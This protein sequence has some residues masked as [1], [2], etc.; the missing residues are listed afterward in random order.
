MSFPYDSDWPSS[1]DPA[2][3]LHSERT[4]VASIPQSYSD[5][6]EALI[7]TR[8]ELRAEHNEKRTVIQHRAWN[9][10]EIFR[11]EDSFLRGKILLATIQSSQTSPS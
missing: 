5:D 2:I 10:P 8:E 4:D 1:F 7:V 3:C 6:I 9:H 11:S